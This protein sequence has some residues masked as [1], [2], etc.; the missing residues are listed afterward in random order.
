MNFRDIHSPFPSYLEEKEIYGEQE[1]PYY[2]ELIVGNR[3]NIDKLELPGDNFEGNGELSILANKFNSGLSA[4]GNKINQG[5]QTVGNTLSNA[6]EKVK[7]LIDGNQEEKEENLLLFKKKKKEE[8]PI[9]LEDKTEETPIFLINLKEKN[10]M[11]KNLKNKIK[12]IKSKYDNK[13]NK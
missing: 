6:G 9:F 13:N 12:G 8:L 7:N 3:S 11:K 2:S 1:E 4:I 10:T 5:I